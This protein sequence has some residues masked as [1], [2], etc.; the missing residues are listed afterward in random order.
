MVIL[1]VSYRVG[2]D[3]SCKCMRF[4]D[5]TIRPESAIAIPRRIGARGADIDEVVAQVTP[6]EQQPG[7]AVTGAK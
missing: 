3:E 6:L 5:D 7:N 4:F 1:G 2:R